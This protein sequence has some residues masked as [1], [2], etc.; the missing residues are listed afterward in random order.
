M[1]KKQNG[2]QD[3][4]FGEGETPPDEAL[5]QWEDLGRPSGTKSKFK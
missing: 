3:I 4:G 1:E 5:E 2:G